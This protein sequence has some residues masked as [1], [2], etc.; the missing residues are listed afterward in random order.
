MSWQDDGT[1]RTAFTAELLATEGPLGATSPDEGPAALVPSGLSGDLLARF[2]REP[3]T[4][5]AAPDTAS[6]VVVL[7]ERA[8]GT[9]YRLTTDTTVHHPDGTL[10]VA[11]SASLD[12]A[13]AAGGAPLRDGAWDLYVR[14]TAL[15]WTKT[16]KL[17]SYRAPEVPEE[18]TPVPH[19]TTQDRRI[20]PYWTNPHRDLALRVAAPPAPKVPAPEPGLLNRLGR[21]LR[22]G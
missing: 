6:A 1:L 20:T 18:L 12:P 8:G 17:G 19:P 7:K 21:R 14:L 22:R 9:E 13:T 3:L 2:A 10:A 5:G 16:A 15:G 11:G 4:G